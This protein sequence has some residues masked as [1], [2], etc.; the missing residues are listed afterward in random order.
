VCSSDLADN[1]WETFPLYITDSYSVFTNQ[2]NMV[3]PGKPL[4]TGA[5]RLLMTPKKDAAVG[6]L[7]VQVVEVK[8]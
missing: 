6:I 8:N 3:H 5:L 7:E 4:T 2:F 1:R